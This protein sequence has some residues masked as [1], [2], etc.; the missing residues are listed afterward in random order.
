MPVDVLAAG[1][2]A[3]WVIM[4]GGQQGPAVGR[5]G[6]VEGAQVSAAIVAHEHGEGKCPAG[7]RLQVGIRQQPGHQAGLEAEGRGVAVDPGERAHRVEDRVQ[8]LAYR[9]F[10]QPGAGSCPADPGREHVR[11]GVLLRW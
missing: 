3:S 9:L 10:A 1:P 8:G 6:R 2:A 11:H 7:Q 5:L 4:V